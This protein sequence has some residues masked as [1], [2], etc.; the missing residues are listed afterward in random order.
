MASNR[1]AS[2]GNCKLH[3]FKTLIL[4]YYGGGGGGGG[5]GGGGGGGGVVWWCGSGWF[6]STS[7]VHTKAKETEGGGNETEEKMK[8]SEGLVLA[9]KGNTRNGRKKGRIRPPQKERKKTNR[10][11]ENDE[12]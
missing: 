1:D 11:A 10:R 4:E 6:V 12:N 3:L 2:R 8:E 5:S 9:D 7:V